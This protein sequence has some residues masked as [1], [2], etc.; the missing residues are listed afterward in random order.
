ML[1]TALVAALSV[2]S[3]GC[4]MISSYN[5]SLLEGGGS[6]RQGGGAYHLPKQILIATVTS[7]DKGD[8]SISIIRK[9]VADP[10]YPM[11]IGFDLSPTSD[12][13]IEVK[14]EAGLLKKI[15]ASSEDHTDEIIVNLTK[16]L[17]SNDRVASTEGT[18]EIDIDLRT[19]VIQVA[20]D[21]FSDYELHHANTELEKFGFCIGFAR[22]SRS[23]Q[24]IGCRRDGKTRG[25]KQD[26]LYESDSVVEQ[27][28]GIFFRQPVEHKL[29][30]FQNNR[31][32]CYHWCLR[33]EGYTAFSN[34]GALLKVDVDRTL[35]VKRETLIEFGQDGVP[36]T[37]KVVKPSEGLE[38]SKLP[39]TVA[40]AILAAPGEALAG[41]ISTV[42]QQQT[43]ITAQKNLLTSQTEYVDMIN[44]RLKSGEPIPA[45][46]D[47]GAVLG[48]APVRSGDVTGLQR[49]ADDTTLQSKARFYQHCAD[50]G[51]D[52]G[53]CNAEWDR[54]NPT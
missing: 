21:P 34:R 35:F 18:G 8:Y 36:T 32:G 42:Q 48:T 10:L 41:S 39:L 23:P 6:P 2:L 45:G 49:S 52:R 47:V 24:T 26:V 53:G 29:Q 5:S 33:W 11:N 17:F 38:A 14:Y 30:L 19:K 12:D 20:F 46:H 51:L 50:I 9:T 28:T 40:Q 7:M 27:G 4:S 13:E 43:Y 54:V 25:W 3:A 22:D 31:P 37:V 1:R 44:A 15:S 16:A